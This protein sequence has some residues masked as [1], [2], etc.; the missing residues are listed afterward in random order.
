MEKE[1]DDG[2]ITRVVAYGSQSMFTEEVNTTL[3]VG[4][5]DL[6]ANTLGYLCEHES[7]ISIRAKSMDGTQLALT[8]FEANLWSAVVVVLVPAVLLVVG[9]V[10]WMRRRRR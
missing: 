2:A 6:F 1:T 10:I 5:Y 4:N 3:A 7:A 9:V 8:S